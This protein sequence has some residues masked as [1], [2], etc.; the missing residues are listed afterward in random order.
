MAR[1]VNPLTR[2]FRLLFTIF[3]AGCGQAASPPYLDASAVCERPWRVMKEHPHDPTHFTQG[4]VL[5]QGRLFESIG[6]YGRSAVHELAW[7]GGGRSLRSRAL[8]H[9][10]FGEGMSKVGDRLIQLTWREQVAF[11]YDLDLR[12]LN[13]RPYRGEGWGLTTW[14]SEGGERLILSDGTPSLRILHAQTLEEKSRIDVR[15]RGQ[16]LPL[17]NELEFVQGEI[18][19]NIWHSDRVVAIDPGDGQVRSSFDFSAL[20]LKLAWP[21]GLESGETDLN[22]LAYD[23]SSGRLLVTGKLWPKLFEVDIGAC[24][25]DLGTE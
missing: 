11:V 2:M 25:E 15:D 4:L 5:S 10:V 3:F 1:K 18:L 16:P 14:R 21:A 13:T 19:A 17:L 23:E 7:P 24:G 8:P 12:L 20:R 9:E 22:G 6:Q